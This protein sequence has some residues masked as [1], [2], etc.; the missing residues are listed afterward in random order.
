MDFEE[1]IVQSAF[2][3][4]IYFNTKQYPYTTYSMVYLVLLLPSISG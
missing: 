4:R 1:F 3:Q 2:I